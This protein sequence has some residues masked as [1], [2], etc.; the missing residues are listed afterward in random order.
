MIF[1]SGWFNSY[2]HV[3]EELQVVNILVIVLGLQVYK[4]EAQGFLCC[5]MAGVKHVPNFMAEGLKFCLDFMGR[6]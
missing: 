4:V 5:S 6:D 1:L 3:T 2:P